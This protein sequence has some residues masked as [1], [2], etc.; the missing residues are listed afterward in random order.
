MMS[1]WM[2]LVTFMAIYFFYR[3]LNVKPKEKEDSIE[4]ENEQ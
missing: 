1:V 3:V 2:G 4:E